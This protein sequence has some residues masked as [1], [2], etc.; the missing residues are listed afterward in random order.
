MTYEQILTD[1]KSKKYAPVYVLSGEEPYYID[2]LEKYIENNVLAEEEKDFNQTVVYGRD[3]NSK[4]ITMMARRYPMMAER[5]VVIVKEAQSLSSPRDSIEN[6]QTY[7]ENPAPTTVLVLCY[8]YKKLDKRKAFYKQVNKV[9]V[10][11][12][13]AKLYD[14]QV[15]AWIESHVASCGLRISRSSA[16]LLADSLGTDLSRIANEINKLAIFVPKGS[17]ITADVIEQNIGISKEFNVFELQKALGIKDVVKANRIVNYFAAN[18]KDNPIQMVIP[19]LYSYFN[20]LL[21]YQGLP[22]KSESSVAS[23]LHVSPYMA[24]EYI[25]PGQNYPMPK[26]RKVIA[27]LRDADMKSK[28]VDNISADSGELLKEL[29]W[30]I[31]H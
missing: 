19:V 12:E 1:L 25:K 16:Q 3:T 23:A 10:V 9:G 27:A 22:N 5:Q 18:P 13:S 4:D 14:N 7:M 17:E 29:V 20:K 28:G 6:M 11:F 24:R 30:K 15:P 2:E 21:L 26:L 8:K 31:L